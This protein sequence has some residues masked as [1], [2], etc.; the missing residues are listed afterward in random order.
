MNNAWVLDSL[1]L[2]KPELAMVGAL[3]VV[4]LADLTR[5]KKTAAFFAIAGMV[6][7][8]WLVCEQLK[9]PA[10]PWHGAPALSSRASSTAWR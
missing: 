1:K 7:A 9:A 5:I 3:L 8:S 2:V 10:S 6:G 4:I